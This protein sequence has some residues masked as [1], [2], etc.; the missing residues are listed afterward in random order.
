MEEVDKYGEDAHSG[1]NEA[2]TATERSVA[3]LRSDRANPGAFDE[4]YRE[5]KDNGTED[6]LQSAE[7]PGDDHFDFELDR[8]GGVKTLVSKY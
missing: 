5:P 2:E 7:C 6:D 8:D 1:N 3:C 4:R